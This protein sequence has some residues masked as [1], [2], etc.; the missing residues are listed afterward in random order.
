MKTHAGAV[1]ILVSGCFVAAAAAERIVGALLVDPVELVRGNEVPGKD[2]ITAEHYRFRYVFADEKNKVEF[3]RNPEKYEIQ[4]GGACG[5]MGPLSGTGRT[6]IYAVHDSRIYIF[7]SVSCKDTFLKDPQKVL[8]LPD[9]VPTGTAQAQA[10]GRALIETAVAAAGGAE[11]IDATKSYEWR[12]EYSERHSGKDYKVMK[13]LVIV[14]PDRVRKEEAWNESRYSHVQTSADGWSED[15]ETVVTLHPQQQAAMRKEYL[16]RDP[17]GILKARNDPDFTAVHEKA[18]TIDH[19]GRVTPVEQVAVHWHGATSILSID[20][21]SGRILTQTFRGQGPRF[22][23]GTVERIF[24]R[25]EDRDGVTLP[26]A[27]L[28]RFEGQEV[29]H[30]AAAKVTVRVNAALNPGLFDRR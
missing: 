9:A 26:T 21:S 14:Y 29:P 1:T 28:T 27:I 8:D 2:D 5:R 10:K 13:S 17:L 16:G 15:P 22:S 6:D 18:A 30:P 4:L 25:F 3:E 24:D 19:G 20:P 7:A 11:K 23:Y 12:Q